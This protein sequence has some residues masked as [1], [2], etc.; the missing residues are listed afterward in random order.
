MQDS[1]LINFWYRALGT[2]YGIELACSDADSARTRLYSIRKSI[3][4]FD[5]ANISTTIS[6]FDPTRLW[7]IKKD[8]SDETP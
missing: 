2:A 6:P 8:K 4:D 7:L 3:Q 5:L 1:E